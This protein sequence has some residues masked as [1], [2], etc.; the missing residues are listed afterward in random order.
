MYQLKVPRDRV[1]HSV[2]VILAQS[3][4]LLFTS[5]WS[6]CRYHLL[7][8]IYDPFQLFFSSFGTTQR[9]LIKTPYPAH[10]LSNILFN[11]LSVTRQYLSSLVL[12]RFL[13]LEGSSALAYLNLYRRS[14]YLH[15][16]RSVLCL[17]RK[18]TTTIRSAQSSTRA[19]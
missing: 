6:H 13:L 7:R 10:L 5:S 14:Q 19:F 3:I 11:C 15:F 17:T 2:I 1:R 9:P 18:F 12:I 8:H 16:L 4:F